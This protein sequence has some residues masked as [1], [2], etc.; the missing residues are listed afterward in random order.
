[1]NLPDA[2]LILIRAVEKLQRGDLSDIGLAMSQAKDAL[3]A[4]K[5][6]PPDAWQ[7]RQH[8]ILFRHIKPADN[9]LWLF[10]PLW[11]RK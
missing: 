8:P 10:E 1:M 3:T 11:R 5:T 7:D 9:A 4:Y 6:E 2:T